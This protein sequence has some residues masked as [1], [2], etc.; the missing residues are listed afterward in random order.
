MKQSIT[1][2]VLAMIVTIAITITFAPATAVYAVS[3]EPQSET[4]SASESIE[5][6][7]SG[8]IV[9]YS[10]SSFTVYYQTP[11]GH[12]FPVAYSDGLTVEPGSSFNAVDLNAE[13][14]YIEV[15]GPATVKEDGVTVTVD[16]VTSGTITVTAMRKGQALAIYRYVVTDPDAGYFEFAGGFGT[17]ERPFLINNTTQFNNIM[18]KPAAHYMLINDISLETIANSICDFSGTLDGAGYTLKDW[19]YEYYRTGN[20]GLFTTITSGAIV[21]N[22]VISNCK[23][24]P[25]DGKYGSVTTGMLC[26]TNF[27]TIENVCVIG[28][29]IKGDMG[30]RDE[31]NTNLCTTYV[32][33]ICGTNSGTIRK[34]GVMSSTIH[35]YSGNTVDEAT[36]H[37]SAG[38]LAGYVAS[39]AKFENVYAYD[40]TIT[41]EAKG[42][43]RKLLWMVGGA[44]CYARAGGIAGCCSSN[45]TMN[46]VLGYNNGISTLR[47]GKDG[48][49]VQ[50]SLIGYTESND[51]LITN[52]YSENADGNHCGSGSLKSG[53]SVRKVTYLCSSGI[54]SSLSGFSNNIWTQNGRVCPNTSHPS[55]RQHL[56]IAQPI[57]L[58]T[59]ISQNQYEQ[60]KALNFNKIGLSIILSNRV[61]ADE[62]LRGYKITGYNP[63]ILGEQAVTIT[64]GKVSGKV[65]VECKP[66]EHTPGSAATCTSTQNCTACDA[67]IT[68]KLP[69]PY[70][71][72]VIA[73]TCE[74]SGYS[75]YTC[76]ACGDTYNDE[77]ILPHGHQLDSDYKC[78]I[79][80]ATFSAPL[81]EYTI[82]LRDYKTDKPINGAEVKFGD[83]TVTTD[84][85]GVAKYQL[86]G[87]NTV[88]IVITT[89]TI[90]HTINNY[91]L[92]D[93]GYDYIHLESS[94]AVI[95]GAWCNGDN[96]T[97]GDTQI[98]AKAH[99][100]KAKIAVSGSSKDKIK[101]YELI[102]DGS[103]IAT[104]EDGYFEVMNPYFKIGKDV[105]VRMYTSGTNSNSVFERKLN[106]KVVGYIFNFE[107]DLKDLLPFSQGLKMT[108]PDGTPG[109][110]GYELKFTNPFLKTTDITYRHENDKIMV[111][112][113]FD[114]DYAKD[115]DLDDMTTGEIFEKIIDDWAKEKKTDKTK[116][117]HGSLALVIE[118]SEKGVT[119]VY[120]QINVGFNLEYATGQTFMVGII[121]IYGEVA[122]SLEGELE[123]SEIGYDRLNAKLLI[124]TY[125]TELDGE[126][127]LYAGLGCHVASVGVYGQVGVELVFSSDQES[128]FEKFSL[129]GE[130]GVYAKL[131]I[132]FFKE[133]CYKYPLWHGEKTWPEH[134]AASR[135]MLYSINAYNTDTRE[136]LKDRTEWLNISLMSNDSDSYVFL[137]DSTYTAIEPKVV[138]CGDS[139]MMIFLDDD[140]SEGLNYQHLYYSLYDKANGGWG[141]PQKLDANNR[142]DVEFD[143]YSDGT[144]IYV[145]YTELD[146]I[147]EEDQDDYTKILGTAEVVVAQYDFNEGQFVNHT[148]L[149]ANDTF[150]TLPRISSTV[151]GITVAWV[152]N[153][154]NDIFS[155][156]ANNVV[157]FS[158]LAGKEWST[159]EAITDRGATVVSM[160]VGSID[161]KS[162]VA[163]I[164]DV[165]CDLSTIEDRVLY[166]IDLGG[167]ITQIVNEENTN[168]NVQFIEMNGEKELIWY[169]NQNL[170]H[171]NSAS[172]AP[173][174]MLASD[175]DDFT[176]NYKFL[177]IAA[178]SYAVLFAQNEQ[179]DD[180]QGNI[181][182]GSNIYGIFYNN[183][184]WGNPVPITQNEAGYYVDAYDAC[185]YNG[186]MVIPYINAGTTITEDD[187][188]KRTS[189]L[190][191]TFELRNDIVAGNA[192]YR[193]SDLFNGTTIEL[194]IPV[195]NNSWQKLTGVSYAVKDSHG[196]DIYVGNWEQE[197]DSGATEYLTI[198]LSKNLLSP[199]ENYSICISTTL[200]TETDAS[201]NT[202]ELLLWYTDFSVIA[203]QT[204]LAGT[205]EI[206]YSI[207]NDGNIGGKATLKVYKLADDGKEIIIIEKEISNLDIGE[208]INGSLTVTQDYYS[209]NTD[210][211]TVILTVVSENDELYRFNDSISLTVGDIEHNATT[212]VNNSAT[213]IAS[214]IIANPYI[215]YDQVSGNGISV[216]VDEKGWSFVGVNE[217][218]TQ[219]YSYSHGV[220]SINRDY[221]LTLGKGYHTYTLSYSNSGKTTDVLLIVE[222]IDS[223]YESVVI[224]AE[225]QV[226][227]Y[228]GYV[229]ELGAD[230]VY[231][232]KSQESISSAYSADNGA[233]WN[234][235][236]PKEIGEYLV[237]LTVAQ[238]DANKYFS[239]SH[240]ISVTIEKGTRAIS[241][242]IITGTY[243]MQVL[244]GSSI[245]TA[246]KT[247]GTILYGYS[248]TN[249]VSTVTEWTDTGILPKAQ[250]H[251]TYYVF[252]KIVNGEKYDDAYSL[253]YALDAHIHEYVSTVTPPT[254]QN[255]GYTLHTCIG[256]GDEYKDNFV[257][258]LDFIYGDCNGDGF[259][260]TVDLSMLR[261]HFANKDP[262]TGV[263]TIT[264][265]AG[266]DCNGDGFVTTV[267]LSMLRKY[268]ANKD[269]ITGES[270]LVLGPR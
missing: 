211:G 8:S 46:C 138:T 262:L 103:I 126:I 88:T 32:G 18:S 177:Q 237:R 136:Y 202:S 127:T 10:L 50:G 92:S 191:T 253:G 247:D 231:S 121:P 193:P 53:S 215:R 260:T 14:V 133:L 37:T 210:S 40:N 167:N 5:L 57:G 203:S 146:S 140:G 27:G 184:T 173:T 261:K 9:P 236:L 154:T 156:N 95:S 86:E 265:Q 142:S 29:T 189:F 185:M 113:G 238:D 51:T 118:F 168:D 11:T 149:S 233:T 263:S 94:D 6:L 35:G 71:K 179:T 105:Y 190:S 98:N 111:L 180:G 178:D 58:S 119:K 229:L 38:G 15:T 70:S 45:V 16:N 23:L 26:G 47:E 259:V 139:I 266:A 43:T 169:N 214:P 134:L 141:E 153:F 183:G 224:I 96:V 24:Y 270:S 116:E 89:E 150:D 131:R 235:G 161:G 213:I 223:G 175:V 78:T 84:A 148:N 230:I 222:I 258:K 90:K 201:N 159:A 199:G 221:L 69:H 62:I 252:A 256:C 145:A 244:F 34:S 13:N 4:T 115:P 48:H 264:V 171:I 206:Q 250:T 152:N 268:F 239:S 20:M 77:F 124:P 240:T 207:T 85:N 205:Q 39:G 241:V 147:A 76:T 68:P 219:N 107:T 227:K 54:I 31:N 66:H 82:Y 75:I 251:T 245:P 137:Q 120:G 3:A 17:Q 248:L 52:G 225:D 200:W 55:N 208:T 226:L 176:S 36:A 163:T 22:L 246:G 182:N 72:T 158:A 217:L 192:E 25:K 42:S 232:T 165:D 220:F 257:D 129:S 114:H 242:P 64:Y 186:K 135:M 112:L 102:Q 91:I 79:C 255:E 195:T 108:F 100:L 106:I 234:I 155:Q 61:I 1:T 249:D 59:S 12:I 132:L 198:T 212:E 174:P 157:F 73:P 80:G 125:E 81:K 166:L 123:V 170:Y 204:I 99:A 41:A 19:D 197:I 228:D 33:G 110:S 67:V 162:Y 7:E 44:H 56:E 28:C 104:S 216:S 172:D 218:S 243:N 187:I 188:V 49:A 101:R 196:N 74:Q 194:Q 269:P 109:F 144:T 160:D 209:D 181:L 63:N 254:T 83:K 87:T 122:L 143:V 117:V 30:S 65:Y 130:L 2:R 151:D 128:A 164:R 60:G 97:N 93:L 267:D 21:K